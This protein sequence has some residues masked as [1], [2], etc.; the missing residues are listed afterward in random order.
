AHDRVRGPHLSPGGPMPRLASPE[1]ALRQESESPIDRKRLVAQYRR[2]RE[3]SRLL[4]DLL[5]D[6]EAHYIQPI[7]LR[8]PFVFYEGHVPAF[9]FNTL[10]RKA[11]GGPSLDPAL[12]DLFAQAADERVIEALAHADLD[13]PGHPLL[14]RAEAVFVILEHELMH[15]ETLLYMLHR[16]P[17]G[18]KRP[19][20]GHRPRVEGAI[21]R[22]R[23]IEIPA[24]SATLGLDRSA[25][26]YAWDNEAPAHAEDV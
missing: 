16:A 24:G 12:E 13:R 19:P 9:S 11:L 3:R 7:P 2:N 10:V 15:Q 4:F 23:W 21:A 5:I 20:A 26:P 14:N 25:I 18:V 22:T 6:E 1:Q 8:H 17:Y